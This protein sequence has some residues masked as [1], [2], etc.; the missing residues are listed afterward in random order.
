MG[1]ARFSVRINQIN[2]I[3]PTALPHPVQFYLPITVP[4]TYAVNPGASPSS[5]RK[6]GPLDATGLFSGPGLRPLF[7][8]C[9][10]CNFA[11]GHSSGGTTHVWLMASASARIVAVWR[12]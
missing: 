9:W 5:L 7:S 10:R 6:P 4:A 1:N 12:S 2:G 8:G 3:K 11:R